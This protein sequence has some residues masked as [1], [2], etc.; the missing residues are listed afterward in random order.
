MPIALC[1]TESELIELKDMF[2]RDEP[3][4]AFLSRFKITSEQALEIAEALSSYSIAE[5][6]WEN[7]L[8]VIIFLC[9]SRSICKMTV[10]L[11]DRQIIHK[12]SW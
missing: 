4:E 10:I 1:F 6:V 9:I 8:F 3:E 11:I 12:I 5:I 2:D 7:Q